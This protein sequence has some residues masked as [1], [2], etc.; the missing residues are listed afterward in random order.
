VQTRDPRRE[1]VS[2]PQIADAVIAELPQVIVVGMDSDFTTYYLRLIES[3][4]PAGVARPH[5][6]L[7]YLNQELGLLSGIVGD[8]DELRRRI[9]G[10][11]WHADVDVA[12][13]LR[14]LDER[15]FARHLQHL[16]QAHYGYDA[17][18]ALAYALS[19]ADPRGPLDGP[20]VSSGLAHLLAGP[21]VPVGPTAIKGAR[22]LL[23]AGQ[24]IDL[25]GSSNRL[26]WAPL[27][28]DTRSDVGVWCL[29]RGADSA[30][31]LLTTA[32]PVWRVATGEI[33]GTYSCP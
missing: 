18:Y 14:A 17:V 22:A 26:D 32:G 12:P 2:Q 21:S 29:T 16:D 4:W 33:T 28:H 27:T 15:F 30:L 20:G 31:E 19:W 24:D 1:A 13:V 3:R 11:G 9:S 25:I 6:V 5:Y 8:D 10:T 23:D 7:S